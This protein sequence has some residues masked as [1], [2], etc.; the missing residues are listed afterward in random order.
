MKTRMKLHLIIYIV[1]AGF[2]TAC[3][4]KIRKSS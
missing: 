4:N 1:I 2:L 3:D